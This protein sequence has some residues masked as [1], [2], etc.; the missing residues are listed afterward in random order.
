MLKSHLRPNCSIN[1]EK[2]SSAGSVLEVAQLSSSLNVKLATH[3]FHRISLL[4]K[5]WL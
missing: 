3:M 2:D 5:F 1:G 4:W